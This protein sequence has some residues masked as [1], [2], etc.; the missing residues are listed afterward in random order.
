LRGT[1]NNKIGGKIIKARL[2]QI[3]DFGKID[4]VVQVGI[5]VKATPGLVIGRFVIVI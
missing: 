3:Y 1:I 5:S 2:F 4:V